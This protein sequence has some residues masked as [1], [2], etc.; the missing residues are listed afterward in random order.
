MPYNHGMVSDTPPEV[1]RLM[2]EK[3][4]AASPAERLETAL[5]LSDTVIWMAR[6]ALMRLHP[7]WDDRRVRIEFARL[8]YGD[9][10]AE[11]IECEEGVAS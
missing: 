11:R 4:R 2:I 6:Q 7:E 9:A 8:H 3:L 1:E 10:I 5:N